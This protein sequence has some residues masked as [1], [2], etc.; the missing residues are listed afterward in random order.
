MRYHQRWEGSPVHEWGKYPLVFLCISLLLAGVYA[1]FPIGLT[2]FSS[3][4]MFPQVLKDSSTDVSPSLAPVLG[5]TAL[6]ALPAQDPLTDPW[7]WPYVHCILT[8]CA[9][10]PQP[11][12]SSQSSH[13]LKVNHVSHVG[14]YLTVSANLH[15]SDGPTT[16]HGVTDAEPKVPLGGARGVHASAC[17][18]SA[19]S[20]SPGPA[21]SLFLSSRPENWLRGQ[22]WARDLDLFTGVAAFGLS[23]V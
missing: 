21:P 4:H 9:Q 1:G 11:R 2:I 13:G 20:F 22:T 3:C 17:C 12:G 15:P 6:Q 16:L 5:D 19:A 18:G 10:K 23:V 8:P 14:V 7:D